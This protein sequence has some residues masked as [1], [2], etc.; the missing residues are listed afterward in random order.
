M[1]HLRK[2]DELTSLDD[3][4]TEEGINDEV[5]IGAIKRVIAMQLDEQMR[6]R[7]LS[8]AGLARELKTSRTQID[9]VLDP[10]D[11]NVTIGTLARAAKAVGRSLKLELV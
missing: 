1:P 2:L 5:T 9:R 10:H 4:L 8:K 6:A 3:F 7:G 11:R